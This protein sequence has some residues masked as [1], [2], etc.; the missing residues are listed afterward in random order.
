[1]SKCILDLDALD[2]ERETVKLDGK[3]YEIY[4]YEDFSLKENARLRKVG[5]KILDGLIDPD[6]IADETE[7]EEQLASFLS[8]V[9][10]GVSVETIKAMPYTKKSAL[11]TA[12]WKAAANRRTRDTAAQETGETQ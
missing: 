12:F 10:P 9:V 2:P 1:M 11:L 8:I 5:T 6:S 4:T 7:Y 3:E